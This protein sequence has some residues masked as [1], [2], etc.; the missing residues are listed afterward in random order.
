[1]VKCPKCKE[2]IE[3][4][5]NIVS[6]T[7][8]YEFDDSGNYEQ[9]GDFEDDSNVNEYWCP[10]CQKALFNNEESAIKFLNNN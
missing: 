10:K 6:G 5:L 8:C 4:L 2:E 7:M 9:K 1:M 3:T